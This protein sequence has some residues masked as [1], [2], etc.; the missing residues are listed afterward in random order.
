MT[1]FYISLLSISRHWLR[2]PIQLFF[3]IMGLSL[4]TALWSSIQ[5]LNSH[6]KTSYED[7]VDL[8]TTSEVEILVSS[9]PEKIPITTFVELRRAGWSVSPILTGKLKGDNTITVLGI[10]P[11]T[12]LL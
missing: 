8:V 12:C 6:A 7:A 10:D 11:F 9:Q 1:I 5:L 3:L 4:A 2:K